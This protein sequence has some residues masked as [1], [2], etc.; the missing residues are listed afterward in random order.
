MA[1]FDLEISGKNKSTT[2]GNSDWYYGGGDEAWVSLAAAKA[3]VPSAI[4]P[5]KTVGVIEA[6]KIV[7]YI[8]HNDDLTDTG[9]VLKTASSSSATILNGAV[10]PT[11]E[12][13]DGD[14]YINT[15]TSTIFGPKASGAWGAGTL[16]KGADGAQGIQGI[17]GVAGNAGAQGIQGVPGVDGKTI[18]SGTVNPTTQGIDGDFY[19]NTT[20]STIF[21]PKTSGAWGVGTLLKGADGAQGIQGVPGTDGTQGIQGIQGV[22]GTQG[23]PG[24]DGKTIL[25]GTVNPTSQGINGDFY[26]NTTTSTIFGPKTSGAWGAGTLLKGADGATGAQGIQGATGAQGIQGTTGTQGVQGVPG[27]DGKTMLSGTAAPTTQGVDG[28]FYYESTT[29][30]VYGPKTAGVWSGPTVL[31]TN[32]T[33]YKAVLVE[34]DN[35]YTLV[36]SD[37]GK[38]IFSGNQGGIGTWT[39]P[40][41][42]FPEGTRIYVYVRLAGRGIIFI[43]AP[44]VNLTSLGGS[45]V[46]QL[47]A[48][49]ALEHLYTLGGIEYWIMLGQTV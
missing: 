18:L 38:T 32:E 21:G 9:L 31:S 42:V 45:S 28:D 15:V 16:L 24:V 14:F 13:I 37:S 6:N 1:N 44:N 12:G 40:F 33:Q 3:G 10:N 25:S 22:Q 5:G 41:G 49:A 20:T 4:R 27:V 23:I 7:E 47:L 11:S 36:A 48:Y 2:K 43:G 29:P 39:I 19:I 46:S 17:Q 8:W 26:I 35:T 34:P 30:A